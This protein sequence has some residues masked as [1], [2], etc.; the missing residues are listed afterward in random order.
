MLLR[1]I[2]PPKMCNGTRLIV[3]RLL[4]HVIEAG[5]LTGPGA[6]EIVL[7]P[8]IPLSPSDVPIQ[9]KRIQ[10]PVKICMAMTINKG[11]K[12]GSRDK[13]QL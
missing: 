1:N 13:I 11:E 5:I 7:I 6:G 2:A 4:P 10:F 8:R 12:I 9:F 3:K